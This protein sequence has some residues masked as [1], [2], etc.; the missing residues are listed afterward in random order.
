M[1]DSK[2]GI[3]SVSFAVQFIR[4]GLQ[5]TSFP[6]S[7]YLEEKKSRSNVA[8]IET[9]S[10]AGFICKSDQVKSAIKLSR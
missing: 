6:T 4:L 9:D 2:V 3:L 10:R 1:D 8:E 5:R 7:F